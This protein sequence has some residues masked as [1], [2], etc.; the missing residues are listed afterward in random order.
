MLLKTHLALGFLGALIFIS[1]VEHPWIFFPVVLI[2]CLIP[3]IDEMHSFLG[4]GWYFRPLQWTFKHRGV[5]HSFSLCILISAVF[6][7]FIP[8]LAFPFFLGYSLHLIG[9]AISI[10]GIRP[11]WPLKEEWNG[12][13][14]VGG[15]LEKGIFYGIVFVCVLLIIKLII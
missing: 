10:E 11:I 6:A 12:P 7:F 14:K 15:K 3:D 2:S 1:K 8:V 13:M 9:D 5:I 4:R